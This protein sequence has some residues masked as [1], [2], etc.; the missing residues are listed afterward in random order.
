MKAIRYG[1]GAI[2][3]AALVAGLW[4]CSAPA[5]AEGSGNG[6]MYKDTW[7]KMPDG[8]TVYCLYIEGHL[9]GYSSGN[10]PAFECDFAGATVHQ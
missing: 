4:A 2:I 1:I 10:T 6:G 7:H 8:R 5:E 9:G 3:G